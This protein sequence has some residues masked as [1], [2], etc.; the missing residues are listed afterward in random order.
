MNFIDFIFMGLLIYAA[1]R[2]FKKG[3][4][5]ELFSFLALFIG[6]Y[7]GIHFSDVASNSLKNAFNVSSEYLPAISFTI[8]FLIIGALVYFGGK[9]LEKVVSVVQLSLANKFLGV[10]F[11]MLKMTFVFGGIILLMESYD[12]KGDFIS[13]KTKKVSL[14]YYPVKKIVT[15]SIPAF[16]RSTL[17][18]KETLTNGVDGILPEDILKSP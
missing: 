18:L 9:A 7:A 6:L 16:E 5:I 14:V 4:I 11:S 8:V 17:F 10:F 15:V 2:G 13:E 3:F 1:W 12:E